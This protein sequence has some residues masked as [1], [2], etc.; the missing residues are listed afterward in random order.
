MFEP[1]FCWV[2][3]RNILLTDKWKRSNP[4]FTSANEEPQFQDIIDNNSDAVINLFNYVFF[5]LWS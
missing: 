1:S 4:S 2:S 5:K 3:T